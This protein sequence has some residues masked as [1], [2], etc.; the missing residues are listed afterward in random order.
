MIKRYIECCLNFRDS[1]FLSVTWTFLFTHIVVTAGE[2][3]DLES[4]LIQSNNIE[5]A[6]R[7]RCRWARDL[8][9]REIECWYRVV[10][11]SNA[12]SILERMSLSDTN[13]NNVSNY[14]DLLG[15]G[16]H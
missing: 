3:Q 6:A 2:T 16:R 13:E 5:C 7:I 11:N 4:F 14:V 1:V 9:K 10:S 15:G 12:V 8:E